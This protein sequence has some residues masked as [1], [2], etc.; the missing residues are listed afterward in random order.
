LLGLEALH[1]HGFVYRDLKDMN[2]LLDANG[3]AR[4]ADFGLCADV[5]KTTTHGPKGTKGYWAPEQLDKSEH[6]LSPDYWTFG[7]CVYHWSTLK[8]PFPAEEEDGPTVKKEDEA[9]IIKKKTLS[10]EFDR[11]RKEV[12]AALKGVPELD[13]LVTALMTLDPKQRLGSGGNGWKDVKAHAFWKD[14]PWET[15]ERG[16]LTAPIIPKKTKMNAS[17]PSTMKEEFAEWAEKDVPEN[18]AETFSF[19]NTVNDELQ[20]EMA[21]E[22]GDKDTAHFARTEV[23]EEPTPNKFK[24]ADLIDSS[25]KKSLAQIVKGGGGGSGGGG[26]GCCIV[27]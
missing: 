17:M 6:G 10:G 15:M 18:S 13:S 21:I 20:S 22:A 26:G 11:D 23:G 7:V 5:S 1:S 9:D 19:F 14:F 12:K 27:S 8:L 25:S 3:Q 16:M 2:I 4:I 24:W